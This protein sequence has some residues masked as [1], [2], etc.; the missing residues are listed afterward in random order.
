MLFDDLN[1]FITSLLFWWAFLLIF[2]RLYNRYPQKN[3]WKKDIILTL[4]QSLVLLLIAMPVLAM[5]L[6]L[7]G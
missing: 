3:P 2:Q 4:V 1:Q 6:R 5:I 7:C